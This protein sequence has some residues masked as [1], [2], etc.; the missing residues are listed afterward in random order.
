[1][2]AE[3][4]RLHDEMR[5]LDQ[6]LDRLRLELPI[7][8]DALDELPEEKRPRSS[9]S[10]RSGAGQFRGLKRGDLFRYVQAAGKPVKPA[11]MRD[12]LAARGIEMKVEAVRTGMLRLER[13][14]RLSR[15]SEG[16]FS[17]SSQN[18]QENGTG[19][20]LLTTAPPQSQ[21]S[22]ARLGS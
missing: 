18:G 15:D 10:K 6:K 20:S 3:I 14:G 11:E 19:E 1:M 8:Q 9:T 4:E 16:R 22:E 7:V 5:A 2:E 13:D 17:P 21:E 12:A